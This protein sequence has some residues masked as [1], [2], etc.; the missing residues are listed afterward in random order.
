MKREPAK[1]SPY[2]RKNDAPRN[3]A[4]RPVRVAAQLRQEIARLLNRD[5]SDPRLEHLVVTSAWISSDLHIAKVF[6]RLATTSENAALEALKKDALKAL[7]G[8][9]GRL[10]KAVTAHLQ[11][12]IAPELKFLYDEG[13]DA[14]SRIEVLLDEVK[15]E[16]IPAA[17]PADPK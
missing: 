17:D 10:R 12:R 16:Q 2:A 7:E 15:R 13:Q 5:Y 1:K 6:F 3:E 4:S 14:R 9:T 8:A 11:L